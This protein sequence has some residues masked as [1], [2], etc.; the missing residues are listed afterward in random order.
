[1]D[2]GLERMQPH[3]VGVVCAISLP[4]RQYRRG[5]SHAVTTCQITQELE[6]RAPLQT[7]TSQLSLGRFV[8]RPERSWTRTY[9]PI[10][11]PAAPRRFNTH[12]KPRASFVRQN[13]VAY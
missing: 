13:T 4:S 5:A 3:S 10:H 2:H 11:A 7:S 8:G 6:S 9:V 1:M 12:F